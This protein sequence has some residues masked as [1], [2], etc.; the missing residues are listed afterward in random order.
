MMPIGNAEVGRRLGRNDPCW[1]G[2]GKKFKKFHLKRET[3]SPD[4]PFEVMK[5][6]MSFNRQKL[7]LHPESEAGKCSDKIANAH[8]ISRAGSLKRIA[9]ES[10][11]VLGFDCRAPTLNRTSGRIDVIRIGIKKDASTFNGFCTHHDNKTFAPL[12]DKPFEASDQQCFLLG[13]RAICRELYQKATALNAMEFLRVQD[14]GRTAL[15]QI[16]WQNLLDRHE[17]GQSA[18]HRDLVVRKQLFDA[19]LLTESFADCDY[20]IVWTREV[21][22][23]LATFGVTVQ[24]EFHGNRLQDLS[25]LEKQLDAIYVSIIACGRLRAAG[26]GLLRAPIRWLFAATRRWSR[27]SAR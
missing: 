18:G 13:Y 15:E 26:D 7:C 12:E 24:F 11:H 27:D 19:A 23:V 14:Q 5:K 9:D 1:C 2:S 25:D 21:P 4:N 20:F 8:T 22:N 10:N 17:L 3:Q 6:L 16:Y